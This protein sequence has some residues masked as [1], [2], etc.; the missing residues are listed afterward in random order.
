MGRRRV[1]L[2]HPETCFLVTSLESCLSCRY[3]ARVGIR[4]R[5]YLYRKTKL[6]WCVQRHS[7][8]RGGGAAAGSTCVCSLECGGCDCVETALCDLV[9]LARAESETRVVSGYPS[10]L[11]YVCVD[12][13]LS[14]AV[15]R[16]RHS[17]HECVCGLC[18]YSLSASVGEW[19][20][21]TLIKY[22]YGFI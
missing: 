10:C 22:R 3:T 5:A 12:C 21:R 4:Y 15:S 17:S 18:S 13:G 16:A 7:E 8:G 14:L 19:T 20:E 1:G 9:S 2:A 11:Q 6:Q